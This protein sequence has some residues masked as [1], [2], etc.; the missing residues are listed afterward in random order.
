MTSSRP[1][2]PAPAGS[3]PADQPA[4]RI[5]PDPVTA[6]F[7]GSLVADAVAM[8]VHWYYDQAALD[9]DYPGL[10]AAAGETAGSPYLAPR[11]PHPGSILWRSTWTP[12]SPQF[13][14]LREQGRFWGRREI[15]YHQFLAA[16]ENTLNQRLALELYLMVRRDRDY[17]PARWLDRYI[18]L[19]L[20]PGW[21]RDTYLEEY[22]RHFFT[23][24]AAGRK[25]INCGVRDIHIGGL[26]P[27]P[28]LV[29]A[30]G[31]RHPDLREIVR[32]HVS[33]THKDPDV[34]AAADTLV[35]ILAAVLPRPEGTT[36]SPDEAALMLREA[37]VELASDSISRAKLD[38]WSRL[39][40]RQLVGGTLSTACY[41]DDAFPAALALAWRHAGD[42]TAGIVANARCGGDNCHRGAVVG[43]LLAASNPIPP[44]LLSGLRASATVV[45]SDAVCP[46]NP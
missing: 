38:A 13:D 12:P 9:R 33:L 21:H 14:I 17:D 2:A 35:K 4:P 15:H 32:L 19:M 31:P 34:L 39:S 22:H 1:D 43:S 37:I 3:E 5:D 11:N 6:V 20:E 8:P 40:D 41:I 36:R 29:A 24:L 42:F 46:R 44:R 18:S 16:G 27:V 23:N 26:V 25:P 10:A 7:L 45:A 28:A 30:L